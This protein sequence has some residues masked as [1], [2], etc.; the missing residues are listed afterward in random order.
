MIKN[1]IKAI[2][3]S[4]ILYT[5]IDGT[6]AGFSN[7]WLKDILRTQLN[8]KGAIISDDLDMAGAAFMGDITTRLEFALHNCDLVLLC[9]N[10]E[11]IKTA[12]KTICPTI[13]SERQQRL[14]NLK[15]KKID[16]EGIKP[17][18]YEAKKLLKS[19]LDID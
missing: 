18:Y 16:L 10:K 12:F 2:M 3:P 9:N 11:H 7:F 15:L 5:A 4:H 17:Q 1:N 14:S 13:N 8:F 6:P 19:K